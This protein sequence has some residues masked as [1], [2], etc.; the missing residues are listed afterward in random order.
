MAQLRGAEWSQVLN[1][2]NPNCIWDSFIGKTRESFDKVCPIKTFL[3]RNK[4]EQW[5][6]NELVEFIKD[7]DEYARIAKISKKKED[8]LLAK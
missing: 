8:L 7:K 3:I 5:M 6:T 2:T 4:K 1:E